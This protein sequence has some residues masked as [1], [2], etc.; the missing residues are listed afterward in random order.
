[1]IR[2]FPKVPQGLY[3]LQHKGGVV[4]LG[5]EPHTGDR[6]GYPR[7]RHPPRQAQAPAADDLTDEPPGEKGGPEESR[8][9]RP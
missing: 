6:P 5:P 8:T 2:T 1:M 7:L 9:E 3:S 4:G